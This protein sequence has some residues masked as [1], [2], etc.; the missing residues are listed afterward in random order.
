MRILH[1]ESSRGWGGQEIR[2]VS[3]S[4]GLAEMGYE[5]IILCDRDSSFGS[6]AKLTKVSLVQGN[7]AKKSILCLFEMWR[8]IRQ[9]KPDLIVTHSSTDSWLVAVSLLFMPNPMPI[10]RFRHVSAPVKDNWLTRWLY[11]TS[12]HIVTTSNDIKSHLQMTLGIDQSLITSI[13]TGV[14]PEMF[15]Q[16]KRSSCIRENLGVD[17]DSFVILMVAT[18][19]SW[20]GHKFVLSALETIELEKFDLLVIGDGPQMVSLVSQVEESGLLG[21]VH[22]LGHQDQVEKYFLVADCFCQPSIKNEG[23]SQS[24]LQAFLAKL[25]VVAT[26]V[27]GLNQVVDDET[28]IVVSPENI[29]DLKEAFELV[30]RAPVLVRAKVEQGFKKVSVNYTRAEMLSRIDEIYSS[31]HRPGS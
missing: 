21:K 5:M 25:P 30:V 22:F 31:F 20:K 18:L 13:P 8:L 6:R 10:I 7:I 19:R 1:T 11:Q 29:D 3:E 26:S 14:D 2:I 24:V 12:S 16:I 27:S 23:V 17:Q 9:I 28:A 4:E 15:S